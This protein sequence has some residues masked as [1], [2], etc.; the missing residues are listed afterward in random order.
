[1]TLEYSTTLQ[2]AY[3]RAAAEG[4][5]G[6]AWYR[7]P[8]CRAEV[9]MIWPSHR[10]SE[11]PFLQKANRQ[12]VVSAAT[13]Q[14][15]LSTFF[16]LY[17]SSMVQALA[18]RKDVKMLGYMKLFCQLYEQLEPVSFDHGTYPW[19]KETVSS[20][21]LLSLAPWGKRHQTINNTLTVVCLI[22]RK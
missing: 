12:Q 10:P 9:G 16:P 14:P 11:M 4:H 17:L 5:E 13:P 22:T 2:L 3:C 6:S 20:S 21:S 1:M 18:G 19:P 8:A 15:P 7:T